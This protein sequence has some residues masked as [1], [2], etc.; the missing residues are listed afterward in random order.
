MKLFTII[1]GLIFHSLCIAQSKQ[2]QQA[3]VITFSAKYIYKALVN[4]EVSIYELSMPDDDF[5]VIKK[6]SSE[7]S[8]RKPN[9]ED[10]P[11]Y[12]FDFEG[13]AIEFYN[14]GSGLN[15]LGFRLKQ[16]S[17]IEFSNGDIIRP[18]YTKISEFL[19]GRD[20]TAYNDGEYRI[21]IPDI[22]TEW[23]YEGY[24]IVHEGLITEFYL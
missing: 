2:T 17:F 23:G 7:S 16:G 1:I 13:M 3:N 4:G 22:E 10:I 9:G 5:S 21:Q 12:T 6:F 15:L 14:Y 11:S 8:F 18:G 20:E 19:S 24:I